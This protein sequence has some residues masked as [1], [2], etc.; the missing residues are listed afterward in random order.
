MRIYEKFKKFLKH[1]FLIDDSPHKIAAGVATGL[2]CGMVP[3]EGVL[4]SLFFAYIF[5]FNRLATLISV[6]AFN[7][8]T[9][10]AVL[11]FAAAI[12]GL[13][14]KVDPN[15]LSQNFHTTYDVGWGYFFTK[16]FFLE[17]VL[18]LMA[19]YVIVALAI[20]LTCYFFL[21]LLLKY[22][23]IKFK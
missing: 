23:K 4:T 22:H 7:M 18:P 14:F 2:F 9:T 15:S 5:R 1:F 12:G 20:S 19:G 13:L 3:G 17:L 11:P 10:L 8:W 16:V 21:Y 6:A